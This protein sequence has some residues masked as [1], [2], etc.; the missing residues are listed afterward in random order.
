MY[1]VTQPQQLE[2]F[3]DDVWSGVKKAAGG[4]VKGGIP[5]ATGAVTGQPTTSSASVADALAQARDALLRQVA[6]RP[7]VQP[8][9]RQ[10]ALKSLS[11]YLALAG[12][13]LLFLMLSK[14]R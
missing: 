11:P 9:L 12:G 14:R 10:E 7:D 1:P 13:V 4:F 3:L 6:Q 8:V 5:G 2:G